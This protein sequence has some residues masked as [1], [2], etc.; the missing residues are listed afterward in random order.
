M[1]ASKSAQVLRCTPNQARPLV[2]KQRLFIVRRAEGGQRQSG[3]NEQAQGFI[4]EDNSGK[5]NIFP[6]INKPFVSSPV[7]DQIASQGLGGAQGGA[8]VVSAIA[9]TLILAV[10]VGKVGSGET[11]DQLQATSPQEPLTEIARRV[12][13][14]SGF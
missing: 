3:G 4:S 2:P 8:I 11:L 6:T 7:T 1:L 10:L 12:G 13:G 14:A 9:L 5:S